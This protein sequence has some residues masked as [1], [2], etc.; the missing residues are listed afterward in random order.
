VDSNRSQAA[1]R[2]IGVVASLI[3]GFDRVASRPVLILPPLLL[4]VF[5]WLGPRVSIAPLVRQALEGLAPLSAEQT[6]F[7]EQIQAMRQALELAGEQFNLLTALSSLPAGIPS[8]MAGLSAATAPIERLLTVQVGDP[9]A[10][11]LMWLL[12]TGVGLGFGAFYH[13]G[14]ASAASPEAEL[15]SGIW[16]W[17]RLILLAL[18]LYGGLLVAGAIAFLVAA[19]AS[20]ILPL[21]GIGVSFVAFS[22]IFWMLVYLVFTPHGIIRYRFGV[23]RAMIE[24]ALVVR[25]NF[26]GTVGFL[27]AAIVISWLTN[28]VW[29]LAETGSWFAALSILGH[30]FVSG[31][32]LTSSYAYYQGRKDWLDQARQKI[33]ARLETLERR[34][35]LEPSD[36]E[37]GDA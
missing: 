15:P 22:L 28:L 1:E 24:S 18:L 17:G 7:E 5:L 4:D 13:R 30:A 35:R 31:M 8:L 3:T 6:G 19:V 20:F 32:L 37:E 29:T 36:V 26:L 12:L 34:R 27:A 9:G 14:I 23:V 11:V 33:E 16:A 25:W 2:P 10:I 21:L